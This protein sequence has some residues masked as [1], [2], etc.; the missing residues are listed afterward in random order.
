MS[1]NRLT[2]QRGEVS[3]WRMTRVRQ[4]VVEPCDDMLA[5]EEPLEIR[6]NGQSVAVTMR[7]PGDDEDLAAGFLWT[8][9][10]IADPAELISLGHC[11][12]KSAEERENIILCYVRSA[13]GLQAK[14]WQRNFCTTSS[15]GICG[16]ASIEAV[17]QAVP[18]VKSNVRVPVEVLSGLPAALREA[19][20]TFD[21]T[22]G[23]HAAGFFTAAGELCLLREDVGRHNAVDKLVGAALRQGLLPLHNHLV[24][25]S[26][27]AGF[28]VVQ[29][30]LMAGVPFIAAVGAPSSL[31]VELAAEAGM[32]LVGFLRGQNFNVYTGAERILLPAPAR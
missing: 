28:E 2:R 26:G 32:T 4:G 19:Q 6:V 7:T 13:E 27:R 31:A 23:L 11:P 10:L 24:L 1:A 3:L 16:K 22:G 15:C 12:G 5:R 21:R 17:R 20:E 29:K 18:V 30:C 8:E 25:V 14:G 9:R